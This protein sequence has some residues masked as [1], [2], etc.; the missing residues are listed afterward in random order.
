MRLG[1]TRYPSKISIETTEGVCLEI[2]GEMC[3][4]TERGKKVLA[5]SGV[6]PARIWMDVRHNKDKCFFSLG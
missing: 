2:E 3:G 1:K 5:R 4:G 6:G